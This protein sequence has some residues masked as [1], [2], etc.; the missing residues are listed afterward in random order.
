MV[1]RKMQKNR[2]IIFREG[3]LSGEHALTHFATLGVPLDGS[4]PQVVRL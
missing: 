4:L 2:K 3:R 1:G